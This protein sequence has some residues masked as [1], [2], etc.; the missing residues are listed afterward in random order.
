[1]RVDVI[2]EKETFAH[3]F[4]KQFGA[5]WLESLGCLFNYKAGCRH[6]LS[7]EP[8]KDRRIHFWGQRLTHWQ[9]ARAPGNS[10]IG[11][12]VNSDCNRPHLRKKWG[13]CQTKEGDYD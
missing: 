6:L 1:M 4:L 12:I 5:N 2:A 8:G 13:R 7:L 3:P 10:R 9:C 11:Q